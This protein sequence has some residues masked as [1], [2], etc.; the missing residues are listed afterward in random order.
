[1]KQVFAGSFI[2]A[3]FAVS[4]SAQAERST[5]EPAADAGVQGCGQDRDGHRLSEGR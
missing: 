3:A 4:L 5:T 1:M 2:A